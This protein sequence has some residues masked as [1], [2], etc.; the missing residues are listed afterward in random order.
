MTRSYLS[1]LL[2]HARS[3]P[4][5]QSELLDKG[6]V[7]NFQFIPATGDSLDHI[8]AE[9]QGSMIPSKQSLPDSLL[10]PCTN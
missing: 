6:L 4:R 8:T 7:K 2:I 9:V 5:A 3:V 1:I 10:A